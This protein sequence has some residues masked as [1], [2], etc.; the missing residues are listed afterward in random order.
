M[1]ESVSERVYERPMAPALH[2]VRAVGVVSILTVLVAVSGYF[3]EAILAARFGISAV[4]DGYFGAIFIPIILYTVLITGALSPVFIPILL[5]QDTNDSHRQLSETFSVLI[6][7]VLLFLMLVIGLGVL[8]AHIWLRVLF[9]G[10]D[11]ATIQLATQL[12]YIMFPAVLFLALA[13][14]LTALCNGFDKFALPSFAP[15]LGS[16]AII[17]AALFARGTRAIYIVAAATAIGFLLQFLVLVP[18]TLSLGVRYRPFVNLR[19]PANARLLRL[20]GPLFAYLMIANACAFLE[21][22]LA[23]GLSTGAVATITYAMRLFTVPANFLVA[24]LAVVLYP[25]LARHALCENLDHLRRQVSRIFRLVLF[26]FLPLSIW[27]SFNALPLTRLF[28]EHGH[29]ALQDSVVTARVFRLYSIGILPNALGIIVLRCFYAVQDTVTPLLAEAVDLVFY[30]VTATFLAKHYGLAGLALARG[31]SFVVVAGI[32]I[33]ALRNRHSLLKMDWDLFTFSLRTTLAS[34]V[35]VFVNWTF[36]HFLQHVFDGG[37]L[38]GRLLGIVT[39]LCLSTGIFLIAA[40]LL[41]IPETAHILGIL[42]ALY[43]E[44]VDALQGLSQVEP[45]FNSEP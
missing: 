2:R 38:F 7:T 6:N 27:I 25:Q 23:S 35:L 45:G 26:I 28:Y 31:M 34:L 29:F 32:L 9:S 33:I 3:R 14:I 11:P 18:P 5:E 15:S 13:G 16:F 4:M 30:V 41:N 42:R 43:R 17:L 24:P 19:H 20:G 44:R 22:N 37:G 21:R 40:R 10:Y 12:T 8:T 36:L 1:S 39:S